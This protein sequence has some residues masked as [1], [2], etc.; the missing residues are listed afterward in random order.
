MKSFLLIV[1]L[2]SKTNPVKFVLLLSLN[3]FLFY[4]SNAQSKQA[5]F[6]GL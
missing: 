6:I 1:I 2:K 3:F 4:F 5:L